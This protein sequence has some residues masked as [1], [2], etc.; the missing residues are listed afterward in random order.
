MGLFAA[1]PDGLRVG[2][3]MNFVAPLGQF[4]SEFR[5][6]HAAAAVRGIT[7]DPN[8]HAKLS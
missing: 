8:L 3:E 1:Q 7:S 4:E 2:N 6:H 5:S